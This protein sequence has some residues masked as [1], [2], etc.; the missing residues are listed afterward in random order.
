MRETKAHCVVIFC[1]Y[2]KNFLPTSVTFLC[3]FNFA[4]IVMFMQRIVRFAPEK[5]IRSNFVLAIH[6]RIITV[7]I[8]RVTMFR[9]NKT[10]FYV[11]IKDM[12]RFC[13]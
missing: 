2:L 11:Q 7:K 1:T 13:G 10:I 9:E 8:F 3:I 5:L 6:I 12:L 4:K